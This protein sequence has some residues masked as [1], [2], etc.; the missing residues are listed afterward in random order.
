M[1]GW[2]DAWV[3][4]YS[5]VVLFL[6]IRTGSDNHMAFSASMSS[7]VVAGCEWSVV[8][9]VSVLVGFVGR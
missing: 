5:S 4:I 6:C 9:I 3:Y 2:M 8:T 1:N 7:P